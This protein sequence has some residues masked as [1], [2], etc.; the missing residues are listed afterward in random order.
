MTDQP[1]SGPLAPEELDGDPLPIVSRWIDEAGHSGVPVPSTMTFCTVDSDGTPHARIVLVTVIDETSLRFH[2]SSPTTKTLDVGADSRVAAVY[3][4]PTL[5]RQV[6]LHGTAVELSDEVS[7]AAY[8]TRPRQLQLVGWAYEEL[9]PRLGPDG[10][11]PRS[12]LVAAFDA[13]AQRDPA[14]LAKP[15]GWTT[16]TLTPTRVDFWQAGA[17]LVPPTKTRFLRQEDGSWRHVNVMP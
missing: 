9:L 6:T 10:E 2:S 16:L 4:W 11:I 5:G 7:R 17:E 14:T 1:M 12:E 15:P 3:H 8:P 13:A